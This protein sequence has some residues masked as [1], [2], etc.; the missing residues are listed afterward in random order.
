MRAAIFMASPMAVY[1]LAAEEPT[2][3]TTTGPVLMPTRT[4]KSKP[5]C[6][7]LGAVVLDAVDH[8][9]GG[10]NG[11]AGVV[12]MSDRC[13]EEGENCVTHQL[14]D[15]PAVTLDRH[16]QMLERAVHDVGPVFGIEFF[17]KPGRI[18]DVAKERGDHAALA[19]HGLAAG[20]RG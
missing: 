11:A 19:A 9:E 8:F 3:P 14:G 10:E 2:S 20:R 12:L 7:H 6:R 13:A 17:G 1:S 16:V 15:R 4:L 5:Y 18:D